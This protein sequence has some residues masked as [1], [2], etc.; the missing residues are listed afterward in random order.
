MYGIEVITPAAALPVSVD[1]LKRRLRL[2]S[3]SAEDQDLEDWLWLAVERFELDTLRPV[4]PTTYRQY[5]SRWPGSWPARGVVSLGGG[6]EVFLADQSAGDWWQAERHARQGLVLGRGGV[7]AVAGVT[8][9]LADGSTAAVTGYGVDLHTPPARV[10]FP[11]GP[12]AATAGT[13]SPVGYVEYTAGWPDAGSVPR[14][15]QAA[16][17]LLAGH[18]YRNREA[19]T[20]G[21]LEEMPLGWSPVCRKYALGITGDWGQ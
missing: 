1:T 11:N 8:Q 3:G 13:Y 21:K 12:P 15:V 10:L 19:F 2:N 16:L 18:F 7:T 6:A 4:L 14:S 17:Y 20:D 5:V 9:I